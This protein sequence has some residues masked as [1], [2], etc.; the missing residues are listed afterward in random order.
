MTLTATP[1]TGYTVNTWSL[2]G[3]VVQTGGTT[4][5]LSN[6]VANHTVAVTFTPLTGERRLTHRQPGITAGDEYRHHA[7]GHADRQWRP[8]AIP[9]PRRLYG[10]RR[11]A[12][13]RI[14]NGS[15]T[16][17]ATCTWTPAIAGAFTLVVWA[18]EVGHTANYDAYAALPYQINV[19]PL[20][21]V[22]LAAKPASPQPVNTAITLTAT[23]TGG[24]GRC[25]T[26]SAPAT[27]M[28]RAGIGRTS[29]AA[30][31]P[32]PPAPGRRRRRSF[33]L[34]VWARLIGHTANYDQYATQ[35]YQVTVPPLTAVALR[36]NPAS[37]QPVNTAIKLTATP[38]GGGGQ[39]QY[40]FRVGYTDAAGWHWTNINGT[41]YHDG[42]LHLDADDGRFLHAG[43]LGAPDRAYR[44]L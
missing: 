19:P 43:G 29:T 37:P 18:R 26:F 30:I 40:L 7:D 6:I 10:R 24:G 27:R 14:I 25:N 8:G 34:V 2:D 17:T 12:S 31:P 3:T 28:P 44:Q 21:A 16:T 11:L 36:L 38:T 42:L 15:Y 23:P 41:L 32:R 9:L 13:G 33:T 20:T 35:G 22:A 39:V 1:N 5:T 4:Y